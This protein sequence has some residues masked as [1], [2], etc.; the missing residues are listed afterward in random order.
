M[1]IRGPNP[2][3]IDSCAAGAA[4]LQREFSDFPAT[5]AGQAALIASEQ[6]DHQL[7]LQALRIGQLEDH[8]GSLKQNGTAI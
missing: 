7:L 5:Q 6:L 4:E 2:T 1:P 3:P 8:S